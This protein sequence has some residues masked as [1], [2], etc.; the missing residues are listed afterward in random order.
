M[1][2]GAGL[3]ADLRR[4][5]ECG[6][7]QAG[8]RLLVA[9]SSRGQL[10]VQL[11]AAPGAGGEPVALLGCTV[12]VS[13]QL[14]VGGRGS[15]GRDLPPAAAFYGAFLEVA[16][17]G[18]APTQLANVR[19]CVQSML[20]PSINATGTLTLACTPPT[21]KQTL[22]DALLLPA[23]TAAPCGVPLRAARRL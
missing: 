8:A 10:R 2:V 14:G 20:R 6:E 5:A 23:T 13:V 17:D 11:R 22:N 18:M 19:L 3:L 21:S 15:Q 12:R 16:A 7:P 1:H 4:A 9:F